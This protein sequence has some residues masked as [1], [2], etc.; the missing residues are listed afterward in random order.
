[1]NSFSKAQR[2]DYLQDRLDIDNQDDLTDDRINQWI[3]EVLTLSDCN[4][5][6]CS[7]FCRNYEEVFYKVW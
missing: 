5:L 3:P 1:M 4:T 2:G 6:I 7:I